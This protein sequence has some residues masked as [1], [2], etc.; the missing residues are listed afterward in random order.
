MLEVVKRGNLSVFRMAVL[1]SLL[2]VDQNAYAFHAFFQFLL[3]KET[4][5]TCLKSLAQHL[6]LLGN[7]SGND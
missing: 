5:R 3:Q 2:L 1:S 7:Y 6:Q 4:V